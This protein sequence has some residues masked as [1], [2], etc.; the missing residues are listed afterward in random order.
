MG[1][2][3]DCLHCDEGVGLS[4][5]VGLHQRG[6]VPSQR[7]AR[8]WQRSQRRTQVV[9]VTLMLNFPDA[10]TL[11]QAFVAV[12]LTW[13]WDGQKWEAASGGGAVPIAFP[14]Q[15]KPPAGI[16]VNVPATIPL[17]VPTNLAGTTVFDG[18][19][20]TSN[21][22]F[23][24]NKISGGTVTAIGTITINSA[25]HTSATLSGGGG[26]LAVGD[27][28]QVVAPGVQ[29]LTLADVGITI[30]TTRA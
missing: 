30:Q 25:S 11:N 27:T 12:G 19:L 20:P 24:V 5:G 2:L 4:G 7:F 21:A 14:F 23:T 9:V 8:Q 13:V 18:T 26:S 16:L 6:D 17:S 15:G 10:P 1:S 22:T 29:D 3:L 28:L